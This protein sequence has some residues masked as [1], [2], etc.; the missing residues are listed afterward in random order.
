MTFSAEF[1]CYIGVG[2]LAPRPTALGGLLPS[3][4]VA[5]GPDAEAQGVRPLTP[6]FTALGLGHVRAHS[7]R[8]LAPRP[9][10]LCP[11]RRGPRR[12]MHIFAK[13]VPDHIFLQNRDKL[14]IK[15][16]VEVPIR[17]QH[18]PM[19]GRFRSSS[20]STL[21]KAQNKEQKQSRKDDFFYIFLFFQK[22]MFAKNAKF[23]IYRCWGWHRRAPRR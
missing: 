23:Y 20:Y 10:T 5:L 13:F 6:R 17:R 1:Q 22:H 15:K 12:Q 21:F 16:L 11:W 8:L 4:A 7:W 3:S 9:T 19:S 2:T 18:T 14:N